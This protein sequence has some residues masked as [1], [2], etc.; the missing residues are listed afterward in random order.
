MDNLNQNH[1]LSLLKVEK[2]IEFNVVLSTFHMSFISSLCLL[3]VTVLIAG[4]SLADI[5]ARPEPPQNWQAKVRLEAEQ[6]VVHL[7]LRY[8]GTEKVGVMVVMSE[9]INGFVE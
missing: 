4:V 7:N 8:S 1:D 2:F 6:F 9:S 5:P 3:V